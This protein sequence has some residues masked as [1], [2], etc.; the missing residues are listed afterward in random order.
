M[1]KF[2]FLNLDQITNIGLTV[3]PHKK[4][5]DERG[6]LTIQIES[7]FD[8]FDKIIIKE[9]YSEPLVGRGLHYQSHVY[10]QTKIINVLKGKILDV[11]FDPTDLS[12]TVYGFYLS[13]NDC[14]SIIIPHNFAHGFISLE[15]TNFRYTCLGEYSEKHETTYNILDD[16]SKILDLGTILL[17]DKDRVG[18]KLRIFNDTKA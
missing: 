3:F 2:K 8:N 9:S 6:Y 13:E 16:I 1:V 4:F 11:V 14:K 18:K 17:S 12:K 15:P 10:P 7:N 5:S